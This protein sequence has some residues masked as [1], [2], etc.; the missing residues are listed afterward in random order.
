LQQSKR[1]WQY[2]PMSSMH[3]FFN[4]LSGSAKEGAAAA[5]YFAGTVV[6]AK[7]GF[8]GATA[9]LC[10][11]GASPWIGLP[12]AGAIAVSS[13]LTTGRIM[14]RGT[15]QALGNVNP[16]R[17]ATPVYPRRPTHTPKSARSPV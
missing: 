14:Y 10:A 1:I 16:E 11:A 3:S 7:Y 12:L 9:L 6:G 2:N 8:L 15:K 5:M 13:G 17:D 4:S